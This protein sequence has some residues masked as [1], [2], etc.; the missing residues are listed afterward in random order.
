MNQCK[1]IWGE[2]AR[3][4]RPE[5]WLDGKIVEGLVGDLVF[6]SGVRGCIGKGSFSGDFCILCGVESDH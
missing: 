1:S 6:S 2:D 5:R 3:V 4:F